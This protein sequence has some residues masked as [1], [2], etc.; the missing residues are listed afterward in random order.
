MADF[1]YALDLDP[2]VRTNHT[3]MLDLIGHNKR[4]LECG[5]ATGYMSRVLAERGCRVTGVE[6]DPEAAAQAGAFC[7]RVIVGDLDELDLAGALHGDDGGE[8]DA[9]DDGDAGDGDAGGGHVGGFDV[10]VF[11]DVL[12]HLKDPLRV[13]RASR[14]VLAPEGYVVASIPNV[15]HG[16][17]RLSLLK[18]VFRYQPLGLLDDTHIRFFTRESIDE[19]FDQAGF[20]VSEVERVS[21]DLFGT[22]LGV[23]PGEFSPE[24][25][26]GIEADPESRTYQFVLRALVDNGLD[27]V[28]RLAARH[29]AR[30]LE[31]GETA[32]ELDAYRTQN[33]ALE[34]DRDRWQ[35]RAQEIRAEAESQRTRAE[36]LE[37]ERDRLSS[38]H[39]E[40][41]REVASLR[42]RLAHLEGQLE[43]A[44]R[45]A[46]RLRAER[47]AWQSTAEQAS[48]APAT[49][50]APGAA[51]ARA[52]RSVWGRTPE[53][54]RRV[55]R[56]MLGST[57]KPR[58]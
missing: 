14:G 53:A 22:E 39:D 8:G 28:R 4:V 30:E 42:D 56:P 38:R 58:E 47:D 43:E 33:A 3:L 23:V 9:G 10:V 52:A 20:V 31:L 11:G 36:G 27:V 51:L 18:G 24:V 21:V 32:Q 19:L 16:D 1:K 29:E 7:E 50:A 48:A 5:C 34:Q 46:E 35:A 25:V 57:R 37:A 26:A 40:R 49:P 12:E 54:A 13:L 55:A 15:A 41:E 17:V 45:A 44:E 2:S 6:I